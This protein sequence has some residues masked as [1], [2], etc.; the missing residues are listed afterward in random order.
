MTLLAALAMPVQ[1]AAQHIRYKLIDIPT[2]GGPAA[3]GN[4]DC[5]ECAQFIN[6][7]GVVVGGADSSIHDPNAPN[8]GNAD[9]FLTHAFR[10]QD[11]VLTD[12]GTLPGVNFSHATSINARG[13]ATGGSGTAEIDP[14]TGNPQE[15]AVLWKGIEIVDLGTLRAGLDSAGLT[16]NNAGEV[17]GMA[18]VDTTLDSFP[19]G[20]WR[21]PTHAFIW[22]NGVMQDLGTLGGADS[23]PT[24]GCNNERSDLAVGFSF[25]DSTANASTGLPTQ[26]AFVWDHGTMTDIPTLGG[27]FAFAQCTNNQAQVIGQSSFLGDVGCDPSDPLNTCDEHAFSWNH[28]TLTDLKPLG[29]S[30]SVALWLNNDGEAVG[31]SFTTGDNE[32]HA[33]LWKHGG[34][35]DLDADD[36]FSIATAI[37]SK[38]QIIGNTFN[39]NTN[40]FRTVL[41]DN[42]S[43]ID[44]N[45]AIAPNS[46]LFLL[47]PDNINERGEIVGR[48]APPGCDN[49]DLC[50]HVFLLIPCASGQGCEGSD[51][52]GTGIGSPAISMGATTPS[53]RRRVTKEFVTQLRT[54]LA[55]RYHIR[56]LGASSRN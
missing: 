31:G 13:W 40:I 38:H 32:F 17:V 26:H 9:C 49:L 3:Y 41:W 54:R 47:E 50:G 10:W 51:Q 55:Q 48:G 53:Q 29:G 46:S 52:S 45:A 2:L 39:C 5:P 15:H 19:V 4:V 28:G 27:T 1:L 7:P 22:R 25:T 35:S 42:G 24:G 56:G 34:I 37:N 23:F 43:I 33:T 18:T 36:C 16:V 8:C 14:Q 21:S 11:G 12:L 30:F 44:L 6:N 20:P